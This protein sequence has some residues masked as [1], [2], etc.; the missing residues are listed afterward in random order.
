MESRQAKKAT[1][2]V[3]QSSGTCGTHLKQG[4][5]Q[6]CEE[7]LASPDA[8]KWKLA[9]NE[10]LTSLKQLTAEEATCWS[11]ANS[12]QVGVGNQE[13]CSWHHRKVQGKP[14]GL[15]AQEGAGFCA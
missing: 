12:S 1:S 11:Q 15:V 10:E 14:S 3:V 7:T 9:M 6:T 4:E 13:G 8:A 5:P 2:G